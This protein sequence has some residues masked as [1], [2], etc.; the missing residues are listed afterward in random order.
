MSPHIEYDHHIRVD[1]PELVPRGYEPADEPSWL[2]CRVL[3]FPTTAYHDDVLQARPVTPAPGFG[4]V[5]VAP[6]ARTGREEREER[7]EVVGILDV[8]VA[9]ALA[10]IDTVA[11]HPD[12]RR[13]GIGRRL[14]AEARARLRTAG[15]PVL[16]ARARDDPDTLAWYRAQGFVESDHYLHVYADHRVDPG[17]P[18]RAVGTPA[19]GLRPVTVFAHADLERE[20]ELRRGFRRV[21]VCRRFSMAP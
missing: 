16:D 8:S 4:L 18:D 9:G 1:R 2:R 17:E 15:I 7:E 11:V 14:L 10:T 13:R 19:P 21:H 12:H 5:A 6:A 20:A 3:A